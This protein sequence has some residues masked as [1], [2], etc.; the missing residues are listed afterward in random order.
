[1]HHLKIEPEFEFKVIAG[2]ERSQAAVMVLNPGETTGGPQSRHINSDQWLYVFSGT[3]WAVVEGAEIKLS[4]GSLLLIEAGEA[5]QIT[6]G[7]ER[8]ETI[9]FYAPPE[10]PLD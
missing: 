6:S 10:Y 9:N 8:L 4:K 5:H 3:G 2:T 7:S 1:M